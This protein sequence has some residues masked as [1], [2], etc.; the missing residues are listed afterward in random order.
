VK[1]TPR[2]RSLLERGVAGTRPRWIESHAPAPYEIASGLWSVDRLLGIGAGPRLG[3][4]ALLADLPEGGVLAWSPV[5]LGDR[6]RE[7]VLSRGGARFLVAPNSFHYLGLAEWQR[8]FPDAEVWLAPGLPARVGAALPAGRELVENAATP[9]AATL[10]HRVLDCGRGVTEVAF[11][12]APSRTL[13]L[14]DSAFNVVHLERWRD[15]AVWSALGV[16]GRFGPT[17]TARAF[18]LRDRAAVAAWIQALCQWPFER[19]VVAHGEPLGAGP[20]EL[21]Q[22][23]GRYLA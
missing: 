9:F 7:F 15:R 22:A 13:L 16:L 6:L 21:R 12:H 8:A 20:R 11:L 1:A 4:R 2:A 17:P 3:T 5:P 19:V 18:L 14:A 23:F 10:P